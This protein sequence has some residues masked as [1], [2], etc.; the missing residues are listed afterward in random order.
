MGTA[1]QASQHLKQGL[2]RFGFDVGYAPPQRNNVIGTGLTHQ[3]Q[4]MIPLGYIE[5]PLSRTSHAR[6]HR[7]S[8]AREYKVTGLRTRVY[9]A[10]S[11][12]PRVGGLYS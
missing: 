3:V 9:Q 7:R 11:L 2:Q 8:R 1:V 12:Q 4:H 6:Q 5:G 10:L